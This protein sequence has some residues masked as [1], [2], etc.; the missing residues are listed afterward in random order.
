MWESIFT[1]DIKS[2]AYSFRYD[3]FSTC[4]VSG[5]KISKITVNLVQQRKLSS[6]RLF[7][8]SIRLKCLRTVSPISL[9]RSAFGFPHFNK[10][11]IQ[12]SIGHK[13]NL[14][15][16]HVIQAHLLLPLFLK[17]RWT[18]FE[19]AHITNSLLMHRQLMWAAS[20][21]ALFIETTYLVWFKSLRKY[22]FQ[23]EPFAR[24][25][26]SSSPKPPLNFLSAYTIRS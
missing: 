26:S 5:F 24:S 14:R 11:S 22:F 9:A 8:E 12:K 23:S 3:K 4:C 20:P 16:K 13:L 18:F 6:I 2:N 10:S 7:S 19:P 25:M 17:T 1:I 21:L 15:K